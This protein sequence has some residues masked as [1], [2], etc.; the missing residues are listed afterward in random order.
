MRVLHVIPM[1]ALRYGGPSQAVI[2]MCQALRKLQIDV[3]IASTDACGEGRL[4]VPLE[5]RTE[6]EGVPTYFFKR[7][8]ARVLPSGFAFSWP[9]TKWLYR[10]VVDYDILHIHY[11]FTYVVT[12][13]AA[14]ARRRGI[15]YIIR[16][17]GTLDPWSL[18]RRA[19]RKKLYAALIE[20][21]NLDGASA[22]HCTTDEELQTVHAFGIK[23]PGVVIP[24][25]VDLPETGGTSGP[26][27]RERYPWAKNTP[28]IL[29]L[30]RLHPK[31]GL[32]ILIPALANLQHEGRE[33]AFVLAGVG[34][35]WYE[36]EVQRM[37]SDHNLLG[38][39]VLLGF[40]EGEEKRRVYAEANVFVLPSY[41][42]NFGV[43]V[44]EAMASGVPVVISN[45]VN[46]YPEVLAYG[47]GLVTDCAVAQVQKALAALLDD[48]GACA[49]MGEAGKRLVGDRYRWESVAPRIV[50][51]YKNIMEE[52][53]IRS[54]RCR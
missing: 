5:G 18:R 17:V 8:A 30:S 45:R 19:H 42:E 50:E 26:G 48:P 12:P 16:P 51:L 22:L 41:Q 25:G 53:R 34:E 28:I 33:F 20:R 49:Q 6:F 38:R 37:L 47:A 9:F 7:Q 54:S 24:L 10:H 11:A 44:A 43:A 46:I 13:A 35:E 39:T 2:Q 32:D 4:A 1:I 14:F 27:I 23:A 40:V 3:T 15:P 29:F 31:K 36:R 21:R 52:P